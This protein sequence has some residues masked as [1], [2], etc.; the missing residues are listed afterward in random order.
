MHHS[1]VTRLRLFFYTGGMRP[2]FDR[3]V[4]L[5]KLGLALVTGAAVILA[6]RT[7]RREA[8]K[9]DPH[10]SDRD[11]GNEV[12][13]AVHLVARILATAISRHAEFFEQRVQEFTSGIVDTDVQL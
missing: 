1:R 5:S 3:E 13:F 4:D 8:V 11:L 9:A 6:I 2:R 10:C 7:A 12:D